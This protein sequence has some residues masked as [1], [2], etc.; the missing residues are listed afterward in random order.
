M[1]IY[2]Y[3]NNTSTKWPVPFRMTAPYFLHMERTARHFRHILTFSQGVLQCCKP[4]SPNFFHIWLLTEHL[5]PPSCCFTSW[6]TN[7]RLPTTLT[8]RKRKHID[9]L[10]L[11]TVLAWLPFCILYLTRKWK[12][13][14]SSAKNW[15][16]PRKKS[17]FFK[18]Q[19]PHMPICCCLGTD[20]R[21]VPLDHRF[22]YSSGGIFTLQ[23]NPNLNCTVDFVSQA[24]I[25]VGV[26]WDIMR[27]MFAVKRFDSNASWS[28]CS[29][30]IV[31]G[32]IECAGL[33]SNFTRVSLPTLG[34]TALV[35]VHAYSQRLPYHSKPVQFKNGYS[36]RKSC[37]SKLN[38][39]IQVPFP[40]WRQ[41]E[42][43]GGNQALGWSGVDDDL[44]RGWKET[45]GHTRLYLPPHNI[46]SVVVPHKE[47]TLQS[48]QCLSKTSPESGWHRRHDPECCRQT[49]CS[50]CL[51]VRLLVSRMFIPRRPAGSD[52]LL[53]HS[54]HLFL[55]RP[56]LAVTSLPLFS[57]LSS[58][59]PSGFLD[60]CSR[61]S[62][63]AS[64]L[65]AG[66][67]VHC[68]YSFK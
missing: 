4:F 42:K 31:W 10:L 43:S 2:R 41:T 16:R 35:T 29:K 11:I 40:L 8:K 9:C 39:L 48:S 50:L 17:L 58:L 64:A 65:A 23:I 26:V 22:Y 44:F 52:V 63:V 24:V 51:S 1:A 14:S 27:N 59:V 32:T 37:L 68:L 45:H 60:S 56:S 67:M 21:L 7:I 66:V 19:I 38:C 46:W 12:I 18:W 47:V 15:W 6:K 49:L 20:T 33:P 57:P 28:C 62:A 13:Q 30:I 5:T 25:C 54:S 53:Y 55:P 36:N 3:F 34:C 61:H